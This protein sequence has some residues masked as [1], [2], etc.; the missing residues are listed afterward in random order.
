MLRELLTKSVITIVT[1]K[2]YMSWPV[3]F[4][5]FFALAYS[6]GRIIVWEKQLQ[7]LMKMQW[8]CNA[9]NLL[10]PSGFVNLILL[11]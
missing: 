2:M 4:L 11:C 6:A 8:A 9:G 5:A 3:I 7:V 10:L 1:N